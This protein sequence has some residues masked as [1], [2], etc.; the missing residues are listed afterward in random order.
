M[1]FR[2]LRALVQSSFRNPHSF[3][4]AGG[5]GA[6]ATGGPDDTD[7]CHAE[8]VLDNIGN[9]VFP[10]FHGFSSPVYRLI[11]LPEQPV[12]FLYSQS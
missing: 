5:H 9:I 8:I 3:A 10:V 1:L 6:A 4:L 12:P 2:F 7:L 11:L